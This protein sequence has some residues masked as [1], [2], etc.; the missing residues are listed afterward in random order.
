MHLEE[1]DTHQQKRLT[2]YNTDDAYE[3]NIVQYGICAIE[4]KHPLE[5]LQRH[6]I[7]K[8]I[9]VYLLQPIDETKLIDLISTLSEEA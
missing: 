5:Y 1:A 2:R 8:P 7:P 6:D 4:Y 3:V 9:R